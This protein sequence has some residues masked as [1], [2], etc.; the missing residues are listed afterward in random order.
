MLDH[1]MRYVH[2]TA[3]HGLLY[4]GKKKQTADDVLVGYLDSNWA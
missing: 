4:G 3:H 1:L 2:T